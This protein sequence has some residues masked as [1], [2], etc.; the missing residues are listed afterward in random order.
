MLA[1]IDLY[2]LADALAPVTGL[3]HL[4]A[5]LLAVRPNSSLDHPQPQRLAAEPDLMHFAQL[6]GR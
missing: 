3:M 4:L 5:P 2:Q 1:A 6:L